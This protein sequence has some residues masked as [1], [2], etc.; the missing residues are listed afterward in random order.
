[1]L[2]LLL[3]A[4]CR[5]GIW[6]NDRWKARYTGRNESW[7]WY[8]SCFCPPRLYLFNVRQQTNI[9]TAF[10][11]K[12]VSLLF[13]K[14]ANVDC[15]GYFFIFFKKCA[16][17]QLYLHSSPTFQYV[18]QLTIPETHIFAH[19]SRHT[20]QLMHTSLKIT[21]S[22]P[23]VLLIATPKCQIKYLYFC[24]QQFARVFRVCVKQKCTLMLY[25]FTFANVPFSMR[26][27]FF[28]SLHGP[29]SDYVERIIFKCAG[30]PVEREIF[31]LATFSLLHY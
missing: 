30:V 23:P 2:L 26:N 10:G 7:A 9:G 5:T 4:T 14:S 31:A 8:V 3:G 13:E 20:Q 1:M 29:M 16:T 28:H 12:Y 25:H 21:T 18:L 24:P 15:L 17:V 22:V 6:W 19:F 27:H 11:I